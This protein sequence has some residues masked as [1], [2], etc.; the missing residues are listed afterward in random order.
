MF[1]GVNFCLARIR[2]VGLLENR[3][4]ARRE[5]YNRDVFGN[6]GLE[7]RGQGKND[8]F[9]HEICCRGI[10]VLNQNGA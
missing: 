5:A 3:G 1:R 7:K 10:T 2:L 9:L 6:M 4:R 8:E